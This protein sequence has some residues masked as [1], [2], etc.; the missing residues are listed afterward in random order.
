MEPGR[1]EFLGSAL[2]KLDGLPLWS[3][4]PPAF[5]PGCDFLSICSIYLERVDTLFEAVGKPKEEH[6]GTGN[7]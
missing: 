6:G 3:G 1:F 4:V 5:T 2:G 7:F